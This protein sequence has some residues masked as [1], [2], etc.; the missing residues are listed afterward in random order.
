MAAGALVG[1]PV[2][3]SAFGGP[4]RAFYDNRLRQQFV[5]QTPQFL[6]DDF[7]MLEASGLLPR[8]FIA[9]NLLKQEA[10]ASLPKGQGKLKELLLRGQNPASFAQKLQLRQGFMGFAPGIPW[11][12]SVDLDD[13]RD[14]LGKAQQKGDA[15]SIAKAQQALGAFKQKV[16]WQGVEDLS[17]A[18]KKWLGKVTSTRVT[19]FLPHIAGGVLAAKLTQ[20]KYRDLKRE[21]QEVGERLKAR[22]LRRYAITDALQNV[23]LPSMALGPA[24]QSTGYSLA[25]MVEGLRGLR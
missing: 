13:L 6:A 25:G 3:G 17:P 22:D 9:D 24:V 5:Q 14:A 7:R 23:L 19:R 15:A 20:R 4:L 10:A 8:G 16:G 12:H 1:V 18:M 11:T 21:P 2:F